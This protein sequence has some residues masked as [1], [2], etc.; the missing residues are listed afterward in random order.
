MIPGKRSF[1]LSFDFHVVDRD[2]PAAFLK[3]SYG[4]GSAGHTPNK[5]LLVKLCKRCRRGGDDKCGRSSARR[6]VQSLLL[7]Q[8]IEGTSFLPSTTSRA[9]EGPFLPALTLMEMSDATQYNVECELLS[10]KNVLVILEDPELSPCLDFV[11]DI[12]AEA[13]QAYGRLSESTSPW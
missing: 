1:A 12:D 5:E 4:M 7:L 11:R 2:L 9:V 10:A 3:S 6:W 8:Q 13:S